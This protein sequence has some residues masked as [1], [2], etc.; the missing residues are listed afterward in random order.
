MKI[1]PNKRK[2]LL[3]ASF[4]KKQQS[5]T[6]PFSSVLEDSVSSETRGYQDPGVTGN[7]VWGISSYPST[8]VLFSATLDELLKTSAATPSKE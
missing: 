7:Y 5:I 8:Q 6:W 3:R 4:H 2:R 1:K